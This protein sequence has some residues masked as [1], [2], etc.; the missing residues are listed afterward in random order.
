MKLSHLRQ[1]VD[2]LQRFRH[3]N[4]IHRV[5]DS[6][7]KV[8]LDGDAIFYF[9]MQKG[10]AYIAKCRREI[11]RSKVYQAPF[12]VMLAKRF[13]RALITDISLC[14]DDKIVRICASLS[15]AYKASEAVLQL[16]FTGKNTNAIILDSEEV[17]QEALRHVESGTSYRIVKVGH[18]LLSPPP[19]PYSAKE[20]P[21]DDV[22]AFLYETCD[23]EQ[24]QRLG[25]LKKQKVA[26]LQKKLQKLRALRG[27]LEDEA[28]LGEEVAQF[29]HL[30]N[31]AL[32]NLHRIKPYMKTLELL[33]YDGSAVRVD[34]PEN[35]PSASAVA[36]YFFKR[37]KK[38]KQKAAN[39]HIERESLDEKTAHLEH[40]IDA[41]KSAEEVAQIQLLFPPR[42]QRR[43]ERPSESYETFWVEGYKVMLG[44]NEKGNVELLKN[45]RARDIWMHLKERPS[46]H[47]II[48]TDKQKVPDTVL[49]AAA[50]LCVDFSVFE[51]G[52]YLVD[53]TPRREVKIQEGANVLYN[54]Y[55][56]VSVEKS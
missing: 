48:A 45:A 21:L 15:G 55:E 50:R 9:N 6:V 12:D 39:L 33:D 53:Y 3:I 16:E 25:A 34:V 18:E 23:K 37:A 44:K 52:R 43:K 20:Y 29:Q 51:K 28:K 13:N 24:Q 14:N 35:L 2:H 30:G 27:K 26:F 54:K 56:T 31:L 42:Q 32:A 36:D 41:V 8:V 22:E 7:I 1:I 49:E 40:F 38:A 5:A 4:A 46:T 17:V 19:P 11:R 47:V 10:N